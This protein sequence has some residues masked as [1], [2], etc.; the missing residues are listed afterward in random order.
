MALG[1]A[2]LSK[3]ASELDL[4]G[5]GAAVGLFALDTVEFFRAHGDAG[6]IRLNVEHL[7]GDRR[8]L[9]VAVVHPGGGLLAKGVDHPLDLATGNGQ[10][11]KASEG[12]GGQ[13]K[14]TVHR[15]SPT[16]QLR[17]GGRILIVQAQRLVHGI[18]PSLGTTIIRTAE[19]DR[20]KDGGNLTGLIGVEALL[21]L[22]W[23]RVEESG[24]FMVEKTLEQA[25]H[26][27]QRSIPQGP[28]DPGQVQRAGLNLLPDQVERGFGFAEA[29]G[30]DRIG[31]FLVC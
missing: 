30:L 22:Q 13:F 10:A 23:G 25:T 4:P 28:F 17:N 18:A 11:R 9:A 15:A 16:H 2:G 1:V 6:H 31:F 3:D 19:A 7:D 21:R 14:G 24:E 12:F 29:C 8:C 20:T 27:A 5:F 26:I